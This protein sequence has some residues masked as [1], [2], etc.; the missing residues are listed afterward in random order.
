MAEGRS[1]A[2]DSHEWHHIVPQYMVKHRLFE[3]RAIHCTDN[4]IYIKHSIHSR[5]TTFYRRKKNLEGNAL[6]DGKTVNKWLKNQS[7]DDQYQFG[8]RVL[9]RMGVTVSW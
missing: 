6:P 4:V 1:R 9:N 8:V 2:G 5:I 7:F 3:P